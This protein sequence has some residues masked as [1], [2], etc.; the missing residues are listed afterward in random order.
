MFLK[1]IKHARVLSWQLTKR[2]SP[3]F[4]DLMQKF[5]MKSRSFV[6]AGAERQYSVYHGIQ[7]NK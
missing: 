6:K 1:K 5:G 2:E 3:Y 7:Y 4:Q